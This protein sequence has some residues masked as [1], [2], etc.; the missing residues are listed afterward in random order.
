MRPR[1]IASAAG[2]LSA[3]VAMACL[4]TTAFAAENGSTARVNVSH[5][6][7]QPGG[8]TASAMSADGRHIAFTSK[9]GNL[10]A[11]DTNQAEDVFVRDLVARTTT[12]VSVSGAGTQADGR[13][14]AP[15]ISDDGRYVSFASD[16]ANLVD[17]DTN[18]KRDVFVR[19]LIAGTT[20]RVSLAQSG[21]QGADDSSK[22][23]KI[24]ADGRHVTFQSILPLADDGDGGDRENVFVRDLTAGTTVR[25]N[26]TADGRRA[27]VTS[28]DSYEDI[29]GGLSPVVGGR[30]VPFE[31]LTPQS[32][33][34]LTADVYLRDLAT[35]TTTL[36]SVHR[37]GPRGTLHSV[38]AS[39]SADGRYVVFSSWAPD[40]V[41]GD[42]N[43][44]EDVFLRDLAAGTTT[45]ISVSGTGAQGNLASNR[46]V[47]SSDGR[48]VAFLSWAR[49]LVDGDTN[50]A[51]DVF[52]RDLVSGTTTRASVS[53]A[54]EQSDG[55][56]ANPS[57]STFGRRV[58]FESTAS[59]LVPGD[60]NLA[61][62]VFVRTLK[63]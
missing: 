51:E 11:G 30:Y 49:N 14:Y 39:M 23:S 2:V 8:A 35:G 17:G 36:V 29:D 32:G 45:R 16:A 28:G 37:V 54:G 55:P 48:Y 19:D 41:E 26:V 43:S 10:V 15:S 52:V 4:T 56:S 27:T 5:N 1:T 46:P 24:S 34:S 7:T 25:V 63:D 13:S 58:A 60:A 53:T 31:A 9:A 44:R 38:H 62:D 57:I 50:R 59:N 21:A 12:R 20:T 42:T 33:S 22:L 6:G 47:I 18:G 3:G 61:R 40:L